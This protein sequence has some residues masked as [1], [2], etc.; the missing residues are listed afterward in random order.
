MSKQRA[1]VIADLRPEF[2]ALKASS[3]HTALENFFRDPDALS[4]HLQKVTAGEKVVV[5]ACVIDLPFTESPVEGCPA[6]WAAVCKA[7]RMFWAW[8]DEAESTHATWPNEIKLGIFCVF[9][10]LTTA[11][12]DLTKS[13][14]KRL[15]SGEAVIWFFFA[16]VEGS[17][18]GGGDGQG[19]FGT[20]P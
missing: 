8:E 9:G 3:E 14:G 12:L 6:P 19:N 7:R 20:C 13:E 11:A 4:P 1:A 18:A 10:D 15:M 16:C 17:C 5:E 2:A